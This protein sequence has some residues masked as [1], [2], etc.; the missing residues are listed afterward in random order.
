MLMLKIRTPVK[1]SGSTDSNRVLTTGEAGKLR[2][3][4]GKGEDKAV[5]AHFVQKHKVFTQRVP[6]GTRAGHQ[7]ITSRS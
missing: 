4:T 1:V 5:W 6:A 7:A 2:K 3:P